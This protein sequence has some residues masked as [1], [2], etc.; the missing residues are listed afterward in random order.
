LKGGSIPPYIASRIMVYTYATTFH[1][2]PL[3]VYHTPAPL[4]RDML[5]VH[6]EVKKIEAEEMVK[7]RR[8]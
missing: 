7:A 6:G 1:V 5:E 2:N 4:V 3:E 8:R